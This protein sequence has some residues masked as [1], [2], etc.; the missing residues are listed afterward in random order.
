MDRDDATAES[1][2]SAPPDERAAM[3]VDYVLE[4]QAGYL[5]RRA[6]QRATAV[7]LEIVGDSGLTPTQF[8][9]LAK[10][11]QS[12]PLSQNHLGR[13]TAM[14]PAT[15]QGVIRRLSERGHIRR[16]DDPND[17]RRTLITLT[18]A[19]RALVEPLQQR[20]LAVSAA[21][22]APL[23]ERDRKAFLRMLKKLA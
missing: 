9:A 14:D 4:D 3:P 15:I 5:L 2:C 19:G 22:L 23:G 7:F 21:I 12:G 16:L 18:A 8:A 1:T 6:H 10:L 11:R 13:L 20:G 17:R